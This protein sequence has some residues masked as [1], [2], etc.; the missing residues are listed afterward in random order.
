[1]TQQSPASSR[2]AKEVRGT[3]H[4]VPCLGRLVGL[5]LEGRALS[6]GRSLDWL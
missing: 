5:Q 3:T 4:A 2:L 1:M 6:A